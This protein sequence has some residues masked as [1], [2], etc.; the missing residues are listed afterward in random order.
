MVGAFDVCGT[1]G[2]GVETSYT[3]IAANY[4]A[5]SN[6]SGP[7]TGAVAQSG[8]TTGTETATNGPTFPTQN[9]Y[10]AYPW[11]VGTSYHVELKMLSNDG[12]NETW[13]STIQNLSSSTTTTLGAWTVPSSWGLVSYTSFNIYPGLISSCVAQK[14]IA[15][16]I[17]SVAYTLAGMAVSSTPT[18][19]LGSCAAYNAY[20]AN[21][22]GFLLEAGIGTRP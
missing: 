18:E 4:T 11:A 20:T 15:V 8:C 21:G 9:C 13:Q 2:I 12:T 14:Y 10:L 22:G 17:T 6:V 19:S 7:G 16:Q 1:G 3:G 5:Y